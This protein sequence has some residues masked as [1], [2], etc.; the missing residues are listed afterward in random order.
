MIEIGPH[1]YVVLL[2]LIVAG[3]IERW[4]HYASGRHYR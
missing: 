4:W 3:L 2:V 1:L